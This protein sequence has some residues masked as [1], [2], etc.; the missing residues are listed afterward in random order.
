MG[1]VHTADALV[2]EEVEGS[3]VC[4]RGVHLVPEPLNHFSKLCLFADQFDFHFTDFV[5]KLRF[6]FA[7]DAMG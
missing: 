2:K 7:Q 1:G 4:N 6:N 5:T 3:S